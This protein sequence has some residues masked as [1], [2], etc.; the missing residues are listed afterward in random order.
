[1]ELPSDRAK[2]ADPEFERPP[3]AFPPEP[4]SAFTGFPND[5]RKAFSTT[6]TGPIS[7]QLSHFLEKTVPAEGAVFRHLR[8]NINSWAQFVRPFCGLRAQAFT[9]AAIISKTRLFVPPSVPFR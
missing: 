1:L 8:T 4:M 5:Q 6:R 7:D 9:T 3:F 2:L